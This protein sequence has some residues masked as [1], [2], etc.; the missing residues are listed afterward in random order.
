MGEA[1]EMARRI[2]REQEKKNESNA[3]RKMILGR[4]AGT[5][6]ILGAVIATAGLGFDQTGVIIVGSI[7]MVIGATLGILWA[8]TE[9]CEK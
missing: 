9:T 1:R 2:L 6:F 7:L 8:V 3:H 4:W 5:L